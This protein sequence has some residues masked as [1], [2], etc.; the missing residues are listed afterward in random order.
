[1]KYLDPKN[2]LIFKKIFGE[3]PN[4][5]ISFLNSLLPLKEDEL[6]ESIEYLSSEQVPDI[7]G[8]KNSIVD[9]KCTDAKKRIFIVEMQMHWTDSFKQR[10]LFNA[11]KAYVRQLRKGID[12]KI[13][14]PVYALSLVNEDYCD[15]ED[16]YHHY[17]ISEKDNQNEILKGLEFVF[18][19]LNKFKLKNFKDKKMHFLWLKFLTEI[20]DSRNIHNEL[21]EIPEIKEAIEYLEESNY[22]DA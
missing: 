21:S 10:V 2:D 18:V 12:Y 17:T 22:T 20:E 16:Y 8:L 7:T 15:S 6:I 1:M 19:E 5:C 11:S 14:Q 9:V 13:L 3:H 4:L